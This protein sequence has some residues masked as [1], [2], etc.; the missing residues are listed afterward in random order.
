MARLSRFDGDVGG[1]QVANFADHDDV[2]V[3]AQKG[4][5]CCCKGQ[6]GTVVDIDLVDARQIDFGRIFH[7]GNVD[8]RLIQDVQASVE[9]HCFATARGPRHQNHAVGT[10]NG[11]HQAVFFDLFV[12]QRFDAQFGTGGV[13]DPDHDLL[14]EQGGQR[15]HPEV[16]GLGAKLELH[17]AVLRNTLFSDVHARDDLDP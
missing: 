15:A 13:Q 11:Q 1:V 8:A 6:P 10:L 5:Q 14:A 17:S 2:R 9:R 7:R 12:A 16:D 3:L 4:L